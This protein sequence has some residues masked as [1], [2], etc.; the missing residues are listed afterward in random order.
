M[1]SPKTALST[2]RAP[3]R[4]PKWAIA[5]P[6]LVLTAWFSYVWFVSGV[7]PS[8]EK[9]PKTGRVTAEGYVKRVGWGDYRRHGHWVTY[10]ANGQ[11]ASEGMYEDG[12]K[13]GEWRSWDEYGRALAPDS[14]PSSPPMGRGAELSGI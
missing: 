10:H 12:V 11:K 14:A 3:R 2:P 4:L 13:V 6:F 7:L 9:D 8:V 1:T 5:I